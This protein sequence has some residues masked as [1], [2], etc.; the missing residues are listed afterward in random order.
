MLTHIQSRVVTENYI[1]PCFGRQLPS[2]LLS[3]SGCIAS[4]SRRS[5][6][7]RPSLASSGRSCP[8]SATGQCWY[9]IWF[10]LSGHTGMNKFVLEYQ[11]VRFCH[12]LPRA[13]TYTGALPSM[14]QDKNHWDGSGACHTKLVINKRITH[15]PR[16]CQ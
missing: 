10:V 4:S 3:S 2:P 14:R 5:S 15:Q 16:I 6:C 7:G 9:T 11:E 1:V 8:T 13:T 12:L